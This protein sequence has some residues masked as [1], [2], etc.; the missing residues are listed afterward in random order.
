MKKRMEI[1][2]V[3]KI[4]LLTLF[5]VSIGAF[6][7]ETRYL[8]F[9]ESKDSLITIGNTNYYKIDSHLFD[10]NRYNQI[11]SI[12]LKDFNNIKKTS[13]IKLLKEGKHIVQTEKVIESEKKSGT[14][15]V[16]ETYNQIFEHIYVLKKMSD[17]NYKRTR[18]WWVDYSIE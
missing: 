15:K 12:Q 9:D 13:V 10:I 18:V 17:T 3:N 5:F 7:Q 4:V 14:I 16:I 2:I 11:D 6:G 8:L 1:K